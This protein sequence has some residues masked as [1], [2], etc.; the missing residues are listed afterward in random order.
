MIYTSRT[1]KMAVIGDPIDH[2]LSPFMH[3]K[4]IE[5]HGWDAL[6]IPVR[7]AGGETSRFA[8]AAAALDFAGFNATMPHKLALLD[9][10]DDLDPAAAGYGAVNTVRIRDGRMAGYNTDVDG[11]M[12]ALRR[13]GAAPAGAGI[14]VIG[15]G[16]VAGALIR[17]F[18]DQGAAAVTV[19]NR[20]F[21]KARKAVD[22][23]ARAAALEWTDDNLAEAAAQADIIVNCTPLGMTGVNGNFSDLSFLD[24]S[25]ALVCDLIYNPWQTKL[26]TYAAARGLETMNGMDMLIFQGLLSFQIFTDWE[27]DLRK[28][29]E[30][31]YPLCRAQLK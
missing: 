18:S 6:Y 13:R 9:I 19:V 14:L 26:L 2:S 30:Y 22:G 23:A 12:A 20:T 29:Y 21:E 11:L 10:V 16:G 3:G 5:E 17:G 31:L 1:K 27:L 15:A 28:E 4:I 7:V 8:E 24:R 25:H